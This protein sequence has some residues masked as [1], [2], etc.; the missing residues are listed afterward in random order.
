[1]P[2]SRQ[3]DPPSAPE[4]VDPVWLLRTILLVIAAA[5]L[6]GYFALC[7]LF[8]QGA[9][10]I[11]LHPT[12]GASW[13]PDGSLPVRFD[14]DGAG[15]PQIAGA[16]LPPSE[17]HRLS[18][19]TV[20]FCRDTDGQLRQADMGELESVRN[21]G[22]AALLFDYRGFGA[23]SAT[24]PSEKTLTADAEAAWTYLTE[25]RR[26]PPGRIVVL[27]SGLGAVPAVHLVAAHADAAALI[28]RNAQA[29]AFDRILADPRGRIFP[30]R[31]L[32]RD[33]YDLAALLRSS[34][35]PKLLLS[36]GP[37]DASRSAAYRDSADPKIT[38]DL[39]AQNA[40]AETEA[41]R[42]FVDDRLH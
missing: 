18:E 7:L 22:A 9:W 32:L 6:C 14:P 12:H 8:A 34:S 23:S 26:I 17:G 16:W 41:V 11:V 24:H 39:P 10:Q 42:R 13:I 15:A 38:V 2:K 25:T 33:H 36:I 31:L 35:Q 27:G 4:I 3:A 5:L 20:L 37:H 1:M 21:L 40:A 28:L 19:Y 30:L 29:D